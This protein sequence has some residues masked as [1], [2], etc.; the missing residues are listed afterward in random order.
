MPDRLVEGILVE[1]AP[2]EQSRRGRPWA[3][4]RDD[5]PGAFALRLEPRQSRLDLVATDAAPL[6][7]PADRRVAV[8]TSGECLRAGGREAGVVD[9]AGRAR[10]ATVA[11]R[12]ASEK[13]ARS[14]RVSS[15]A[16][17][18]SR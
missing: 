17:A 9:E 6:E 15:S 5:S 16:V 7:V 3:A 2:G 18:R 8:T 12:S 14:R 1:A 11:S 10:R 13:P 4:L